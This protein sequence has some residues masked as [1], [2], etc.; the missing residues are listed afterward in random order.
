MTVT[1]PLYEIAA[2]GVEAPRVRAGR[3]AVIVRP[4]LLKRFQGVPLRRI[5]ER[6]LRC[7]ILVGKMRVHGIV[8]CLDKTNQ[9][10]GADGL[11]G[12]MHSIVITGPLKRVVGL[13]AL[14]GIVAAAAHV[15]GKAVDPVVD[16][17]EAMD[18]TVP[19]VGRDIEELRSL[20]I[21]LGG[22]RE[23]PCLILRRR[24]L[25]EGGVLERR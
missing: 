14:E 19:D 18:L 15:G 7:G 6:A 22:H 17:A 5:D 1:I 2:L 10:I 23:D 20:I 24:F 8:A 9:G 4:F 13:R 12:C 3:I 25:V 11:P 16:V 21:D